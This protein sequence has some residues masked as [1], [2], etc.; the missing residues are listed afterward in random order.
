MSKHFIRTYGF[1]ED[2]RNASYVPWT[3][4]EGK[5]FKRLLEPS[6]MMCFPNHAVAHY[7]R[8][9][10][11]VD[12]PVALIE[13]CAEFA[14][15]YPE[16]GAVLIHGDH[17]DFML[18]QPIRTN[19]FSTYPR[20]REFI[21]I[22]NARPMP[23]VCDTDNVIDVGYDR[24]RV[25]YCPDS[26]IIWDAERYYR[27]LGHKYELWGIYRN[28]TKFVSFTDDVMARRE[29]DEIVTAL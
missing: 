22:F 11:K 10:G 14:R 15:E 12:D 4:T 29:G 2:R 19:V 3:N 18:T 17:D 9:L 13:E 16:P 28:T 25:K 1:Y 23:V 27:Q 20:E 21:V 7:R 26:I 8:S 6:E 5:M 24:Y